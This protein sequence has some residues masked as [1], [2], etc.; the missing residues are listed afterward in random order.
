MTGMPQTLVT[1]QTM[2]AIQLLKYDTSIPHTLSAVVMLTLS[3][4][5][6]RS[7]TR[8]S[9]VQTKPTN[10]MSAVSSAVSHLVSRSSHTGKKT[11][12]SD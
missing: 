9:D 1:L 10:T 5:L 2:P 6:H 12:P 11:T 3:L 4:C 8:L 7:S